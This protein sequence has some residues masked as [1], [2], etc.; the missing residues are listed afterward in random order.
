MDTSINTGTNWKNVNNWHW[1]DK[2]CLPWAKEYFTEKLQNLENTFD[3]TTIK[4][5]KVTVRGDCDLNQRKGQVI[6]IYDLS[7]T[8]EWSGIL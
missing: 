4:I 3:D 7:F 6:H 8:L 1:V 5:T 2:N